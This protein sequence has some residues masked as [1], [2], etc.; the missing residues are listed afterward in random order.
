MY[1]VINNA[2]VKTEVNECYAITAA[3]YASIQLCGL[4]LQFFLF[5]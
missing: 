3:H 1:I 5:I 4:W 2:T